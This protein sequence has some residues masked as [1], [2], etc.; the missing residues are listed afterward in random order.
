MANARLSR[1]IPG[2]GLD[3]PAYPTAEAGRFVGLAPG[4]VRRWLQGYEFTYETKASPRFHRSRKKPVVVAESR[5]AARYASFLDLI[6]LLL[7]REFLQL[8][9]S[10]QKIRRA[11]DEV[12]QRRNITH[13]AYETFFTLGKRIYLEFQ[14]LDGAMI[15]LMTGGQMAFPS[16]IAQLGRQ[17]EF[18]PNTKMAVRWYPLHPDRLVVIDPFVSFGHP[19]ISGR[20]ITTSTVVDLFFAEGQQLDPVCDWMGVS[21]AEVTAAVRFENMLAM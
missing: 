17:I 5:P 13:L 12:R 19:T 2:F 14:D 8:G 9:V 15:E 10:L 3:S 4:R 21:P 16:M 7:V 20:R 6:D 1:E 18:D 11:F